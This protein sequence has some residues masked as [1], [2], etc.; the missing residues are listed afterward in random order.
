MI[1]VFDLDD[2]LY[3]E[4]SYVR[5]G[6][7]AV[8]RYMEESYGI[9]GEK[10]FS[11][12]DRQLQ[13]GRSGVFDAVF[14]ALGVYSKKLV[15]RCLSLYRLHQPQIALYP[16]AARCLKRLEAYPLYIVTDGNINAQKNKLT[17]LCLYNQP[18][19]RRCYLTY[20]YGVRHSKPSPYCFQK[21]AAREGVANA[22]V[23]Y[24]A[25][26]PQK[27]FVGIKPLGFQTIRVFTGQHS[28]MRKNHDYEADYAV[29]SL[30]DLTED[31]LRKVVA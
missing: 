27:D 6:F 22:E 19:I 10:V 26:N 18:P 13:Q 8:A 11:L 4:L 20:R 9:P 29:S 24:I 2:T 15:R 16:E 5:S 23:A 12:C 3:D 1:L 17:A 14:K 7:W 31:F 28:M 25:D 30:D 21:I